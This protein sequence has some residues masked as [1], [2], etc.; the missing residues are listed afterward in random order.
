MSKKILVTGGAGFLGSHLCDRLIENGNKVICVDNLSTGSIRNIEHLLDNDNFEFIKQDIIEPFYREIDQIYNLACPASPVK[1]QENPV[2]TIKTNSI[3]VL[4]LLELCK[5]QG[6]RLL[7]C[8]TSEIYG[9]AEVNPQSENYLG[10][11]NTIGIRA[12]YDEGKRLAETLCMDYLRQFGV[13]VK[14]IRIF[15]TY[16]PRMQIDDGRVVS[17]FIVQSLLQQDITVYGDGTQTRSFCYVDDLIQGMMIMMESRGDFHGPVNMG[18]PEEITVMELIKK[19][20]AITGSKSKIRLCPLPE[21][22]P[23]H[24]RPDVSLAGKELNWK[25]DISLEQG[26]SRTIDYFKNILPLPFI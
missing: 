22:D 4:N 12:C 9:K 16:G 7:Q 24:R 21:D 26:L 17:N 2:Q 23:T 14:I 1:Y 15:N 10:N 8:S 19:I 13:D 3:G 6:A 5:K 18:N 11:V 20:L 25:A